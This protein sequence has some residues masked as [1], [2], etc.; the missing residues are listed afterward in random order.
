MVTGMDMGTELKNLNAAQPVVRNIDLRD[1]ASIDT[2]AIEI[3]P[4]WDLP[5]SRMKKGK[6]FLCPLSPLAIELIKSSP[7]TSKQVVAAPGRKKTTVSK[8][9]SATRKLY[10]AL[11]IERFTPHDLRRTA[12]T[13]L[14]EFGWAS[15]DTGLLLAH[16]P[17]SV[18]GKVY[19]HSKGL[20]KKRAMVLLLEKIITDRIAPDATTNVVPLRAA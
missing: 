3:G 18:T 10:A 15:H 1:V 16:A 12:G 20:D 17:V 2:R 6:R 7:S 14:G 13:M 11:G 19:D 9:S 4:V 8:L 5:G